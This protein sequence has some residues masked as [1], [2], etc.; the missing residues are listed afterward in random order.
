MLVSLRSF[1]S[2]YVLRTFHGFKNN[3]ILRRFASTIYS[4]SSGFGKSGVAVIRVSGPEAKT[5][6][7]KLGGSLPKPRYASLRKFRHPLTNDVLDNGILLW[8][9]G[10]KS[11]TGEDCCEFQV[12]GGPAVISSVLDALGKINGLRPAEQ[13]EFTKRAFYSGKLDLTSVEGLADLIN[14]ETENQRKQAIIQ[15]EGALFDLYNDWTK[16]LTKCL[17]NLEAYIDF[18]ED[19]NLENT[20]MAD[21]DKKLNDLKTS[22]KN[23]LQ[24]GRKG[25]RLRS[26]VSV[27]IIGAP[28]VGKSSLLNILSRQ[29]TAIVSPIPGTTRDLIKTNID[30]NGYPVNINDTA[31]LR[32][33]TEDLIEV[34][35]MARAKRAAEQSDLLILVLDGKEL[36][37]WLRKDNLTPNADSLYYYIDSLNIFEDIKSYLSINKDEIVSS[38]NKQVMI[39]VNKIDLITEEEA[40]LSKLKFICGISCKNKTGLQKLIKGLSKNLESL[41]GSPNRL[42]PTFTQARHRFCLQECLDALEKFSNYSISEVDLA[43]QEIRNALYSLGKITGHVTTEDILEVIFK[44]FCIGK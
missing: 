5:A 12:H 10:P 37:S 21:T 31:G 33:F 3:K 42:S 25:E 32:G 34:E 16:T 6:A 38:Q 23:H 22:I 15:M 41:C 9:P 40:A 1:T 2:E 11:F 18:D 24:D 14:A 7:E 20:L 30:I 43:A 29:P 44:D 36:L 27:T 19:Q 8:F 4:L 26:G 13:G 17:A 28:N 35:G 39:I